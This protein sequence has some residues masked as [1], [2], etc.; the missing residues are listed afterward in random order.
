MTHSSGG[1]EQIFSNML[2]LGV[3]PTPVSG[4]LL[5]RELLPLQ[6]LMWVLLILLHGGKPWR[7][8]LSLSLLTVSTQTHH[9]SHNASVLQTQWNDTDRLPPHTGKW[10]REYISTF[11]SCFKQWLD[12]KDVHCTRFKAHKSP[13]QVRHYK[14]LVSDNKE[15]WND[16]TVLLFYPL[17]V[18]NFSFLIFAVK[19]LLLLMFL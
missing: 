15:M 7:C 1:W 10:C 18:F 4:G 13:P 14:H 9:R 8:R 6:D 16:L 11:C 3:L 19:Y 5:H 12:D 2:P 17:N